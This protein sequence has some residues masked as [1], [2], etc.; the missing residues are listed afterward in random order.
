MTYPARTY[1]KPKTSAATIR[2]ARLNLEF[3][4]N[5]QRQS[6]GDGDGISLIE[7]IVFGGLAP[8][9]EQFGLALAAAKQMRKSLAGMTATEKWPARGGEHPLVSLDDKLWY[10]AGNRELSPEARGIIRASGHR[11]P[12]PAASVPMPVPLRL[13]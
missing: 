3:A 10:V 5:V 12:A 8:D 13:A 6:D 4:A 7:R 9:Q 1:A 11:T 2:L